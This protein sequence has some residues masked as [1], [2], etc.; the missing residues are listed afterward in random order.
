MLFGEAAITAKE[1]AEKLVSGVLKKM[2]TG[3]EPP[4]SGGNKTMW[5]VQ[6]KAVLIEIGT[7]FKYTSLCEWCSLDMI[8]WCMSTQRLILVAESEMATNPDAI[9]TDFEKLSVFKCPLKL[10]VFSREVERVKE[11]AESYLRVLTQHVKDEEYLLVGFTASGPRCFLFKVPNDGKVDKVKFDELR[12][13]K[14]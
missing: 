13:P 1:L 6:V 10:L 2:G 14:Y 8:W 12:L 4:C 7:T 5:T 11:N 3:S 9:E